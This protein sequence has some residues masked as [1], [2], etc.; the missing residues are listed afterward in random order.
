MLAPTPPLRKP[1]HHTDVYAIVQEEL[2]ENDTDTLKLR[3]M[4]RV[5]SIVG[6]PST[7]LPERIKTWVHQLCMRVTAPSAP[8]RPFRGALAEAIDLDSLP[9][10]KK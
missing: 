5:A 8:I 9:N 2:K 3:V 10:R 6:L 4:G 7:K 1:F